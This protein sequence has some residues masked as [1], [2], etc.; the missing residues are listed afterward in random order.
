M[1]NQYMINSLIFFLV[2]K[3]IINIELNDIEDNASLLSIA[4]ITLQN[5]QEFPFKEKLGFNYTNYY[6]KNLSIIS[7]EE[8]TQLIIEDIQPFI[9]ISDDSDLILINEEDKSF[10]FKEI[11]INLKFNLK[12]IHY[13]KT[14]NSTIE[15]YK[16]N[17]FSN[18]KV[19]NIIFKKR[20][21][22]ERF[23]LFNYFQE[24]ELISQIDIFD[25]NLFSAKKNEILAFISDSMKDSTVNYI[26]NIIFYY[27]QSESQKRLQYMC[28]YLSNN[29]TYRNYKTTGL[30]KIVFIKTDFLMDL[31]GTIRSIIFNID[32]SVSQKYY[33][34][35]YAI[36][37]NVTFTSVFDCKKFETSFSKNVVDM[38][39]FYNG[40]AQIVEDNY[41][42]GIY[43]N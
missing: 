18:N 8:P 37:Y 38:D 27:P 32:F 17:L 36:A 1:T 41:F 29:V 20:K 25:N 4:K 16:S 11:F 9:L 22:S 40:L 34:N 28:E 13:S 15:L 21:N 26:K 6:F 33:R 14:T 30:N 42:N 43:S 7:I 23:E 31:D 5:L 35:E 3:F 2:L 12:I 19:S 39:D 10:Y 24:D